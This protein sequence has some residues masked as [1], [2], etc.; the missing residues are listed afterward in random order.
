M[1]QAQAD[2]TLWIQAPGVRRALDQFFIHVGLPP[3]H[4]KDAQTKRRTCRCPACLSCR[5]ESSKWRGRNYLLYQSLIDNEDLGEMIR[6]YQRRA[7]I[8][9]AFPGKKQQ[10]IDA[11]CGQ[12]DDFKVTDV[13]DLI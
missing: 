13:W 2:G 11:M 1:R 7:L 5:A 4:W 12:C 9:A 6:T 3:F 8:V 10:D